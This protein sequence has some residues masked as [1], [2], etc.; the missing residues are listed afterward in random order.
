MIAISPISHLCGTHQT[1]RF[2]ALSIVTVIPMN[3]TNHPID[4]TTPATMKGVQLI[5]HGGLDQLV[6][7]EDI[8][9]PQPKKGEVLLKVLA[10]GVNNTDINTRIGWYSKQVT[11]DTNS[12]ADQGYDEL[13]ATTATWSGSALQL[14]RIQGA[15]VCGE[16]IA[17]GTGVSSERIGERV[18]VRTMQ[19]HPTKPF[20]CIT[21]GS[22]YDGGFA[23]YTCALSNEA[24]AVNTPWSDVELASIPCA[25]STAEN[26]LHRAG[27]KPGER[28]L[29]TGA[30]GGVGSAAVQLAKRRG[31]YVIAVAGVTKHDDVKA[32]G[33]DQL[34]ARGDDL[35]AAIGA[36]AVDVV[37]DLVAGPDWPQL[38]D[39][40]RR[41]GRY[42]TSGA[43]AGP[44]VELDVRTLYLKDLTFF[45]CTYQDHI[46]FTNLVSY[47]EAEE[48]RPVVAHSY[49]LKQIHQA[50]TDFMNKGFTGKLVLIPEA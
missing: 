20:V 45:G 38:L 5:G 34:V 19:Q 43:I 33:A 42:A 10:A 29:I 50:Q 47:I 28:V 9:T 3:P 30:S 22:E 12:G 21:F 7:R 44:M 18:L 39:V 31:A 16:V 2:V 32:L 41:G 4:A 13:D 37:V 24:Y 25:Y 11:G 48:I 6:Y 46:V 14:P 49:P 27:L 26:M 8:P 36:D 17:V 15:D 35:V 23:Q 40:L 1:A